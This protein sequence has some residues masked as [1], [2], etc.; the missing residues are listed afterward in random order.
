MA[1][2]HF[3]YL[4]P[5]FNILKLLN[6]FN[7]LNILRRATC[8]NILKYSTTFN[9]L[10]RLNRIA[11]FTRVEVDNQDPRLFSMRSSTFWQSVTG[12][13]TVVA[14]QS[15]HSVGRLAC[16]MPHRDCLLWPGAC[17]KC[18][19]AGLRPASFLITHVQ[20]SVYL[21]GMFHATS[22]LSSVAGCL[23]N[24]F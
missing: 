7:I 18:F 3:Q 2:E 16:S 17:S 23:V 9:I 1:D 6:V 15:F 13:M 5:C 21:A 4:G 22:G 19:E 24:A 20:L 11:R 8:F 14:M 12:Q 10:N